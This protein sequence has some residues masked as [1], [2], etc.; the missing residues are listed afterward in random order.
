MTFDE[1][2]DYLLKMQSIARIGLTY[3]TD[4]Y[5]IDNY[6]QINDLTL[7]MLQNL[8]DVKLDR[9]NYFREGIYPTPN[10]SCRAVIINDKKQILL[11]REV[12]SGKYSMPGGWCDLYDSPKQAII[13]ECKQE[14]GANVEII[15]LIG[16]TNRTPYKF[17]KSVPE[18]VLLFECKVVGELGTH[19]YETDDVSY[20]DIDNLPSMS[21]KMSMEEINNCIDA[22]INHKYLLD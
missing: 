12:N 6:H 4:S 5:A 11:V 10:I 15:R 3:S 22:V 13:N 2:F 8:Q 16:V 1:L 21:R 20:F 7:E 9:N 18:Y 19:E 14:A 17:N